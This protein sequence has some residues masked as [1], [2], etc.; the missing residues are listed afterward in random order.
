MTETKYQRQWIIQRH[1][2]QWKIQNQIAKVILELWLGELSRQKNS[3]S[4]TTGSGA[5]D[6]TTVEDS[7]I[8]AKNLGGKLKDNRHCVNT[9]GRVWYWNWI[10]RTII[11]V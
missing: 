9:Q 1:K 2:K 10:L 8:T 3:E 7:R 6:T 4:T 11:Q 5:D